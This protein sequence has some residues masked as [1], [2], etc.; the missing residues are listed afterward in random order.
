[1]PTRTL[2]DLAADEFVAV[3]PTD[4]AAARIDP[5]SG[6]VAYCRNGQL[7]VDFEGNRYGAVNIVTW[8]DRVFHAYG[9]ASTGY[10][11]TAR[12]GVFDP[13]SYVVVGELDVNERRVRVD[14]AAA[15][16]LEAWLG[17]PLSD[18]ELAC[19]G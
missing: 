18:A 8:A 13:N 6:A 3:V 16:L 10:P 9:R 17:R 12:A 5:A 2:E 19:S 4:M 14:P 1:M 7:L 11:T 15:G